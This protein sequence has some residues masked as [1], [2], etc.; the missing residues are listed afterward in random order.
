MTDMAIV[1]GSA[2]ETA[3]AGSI[4]D[5]GDEQL[6]RLLAERAD[7]QGISLAGEGGLLA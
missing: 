3:L 6:V 1:E 5:A 4:L 2:A 7:S